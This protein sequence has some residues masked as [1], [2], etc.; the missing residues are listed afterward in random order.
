MLIRDELQGT[1]LTGFGARVRELREQS[2]I[3]QEE[4]A[5]LAGLDR[6]YI[7][8]VE[9]GERNLSL[10]NI[11]KIAKGLNVPLRDLFTILDEQA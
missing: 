8:Q 2:R 11:F 5:H 4:F 3:S 9:R 6:S 10:F 7:G 1:V